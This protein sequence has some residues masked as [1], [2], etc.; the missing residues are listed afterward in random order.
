MTHRA[1]LWVGQD[2]NPRVKNLLTPPV[3]SLTGGGQFFVS[4]IEVQG[5]VIGVFYADRKPSGRP[6]DEDSF[7]A[8]KHFCQQANLALTYSRRSR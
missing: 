6:L 4:P 3:Q 5:N 7:T 1:S 2:I 8:F